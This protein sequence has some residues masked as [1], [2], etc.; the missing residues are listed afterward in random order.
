MLQATKK[1]DFSSIDLL[2]RQNVLKNFYKTG[3]L[4]S[5]GALGANLIADLP[6]EIE[7][8][9]FHFACNLGLAFQT[10]DD[11][12]DF[13]SDFQTL[14]KEKFQDLQLGIV[15]SPVLFS[16]QRADENSR[17]GIQ[18]LLKQKSINLS[19]TE[20]IY[21]FIQ[22]F[23]GVQDATLL[24]ILFIKDAFRCLQSISDHYNQEVKFLGLKWLCTKVITRS[25]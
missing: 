3:S 10:I 8:K 5:Y 2:P 24:A 15:N 14:G 19:E 1:K 18:K 9:V 13:T 20:E 4:M 7:T 17:I 6:S 22:N 25:H 16:L 11:V 21:S 23:G 12:I